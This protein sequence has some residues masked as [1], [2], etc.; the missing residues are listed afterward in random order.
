MTTTIRGRLRASGGMQRL[1]CQQRRLP[2][3]RGTPRRRRLAVCTLSQLVVPL[4]PLNAL[5]LALQT[6]VAVLLGA[7]LLDNLVAVRGVQL[8]DELRDEV[9]VLQRLLH[10]G[11]RRARLLALAGVCGVAADMLARVGLLEVQL[12]A[13]AL[14]V[15]VAQGVRA[16]AAAL[17]ELVAG[18]V[19]VLLEQVRDAAKHAGADAIGVQ[20]LEQQ[21]RLEGGV[22]SATGTHPPQPEGVRGARRAERRGR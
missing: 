11:Q 21:Q 2:G 1:L 20:A 3:Q 7:D 8:V 22:G 14:E 10:R 5:Q 9:R 15:E 4:A 19:R 13:Q 17:E 12:P 18:D 6:V 16:Q